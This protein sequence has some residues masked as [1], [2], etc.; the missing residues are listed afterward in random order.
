MSF[1]RASVVETARLSARL[2]RVVLQVH[3]PAA[4]DVPSAGDS[5]IGLY[6]SGADDTAESSEGR[7]YSVRCHSGNRITVDVVLHT[8][9]PGTEWASTTEPGARVGLDHA[10]SWYR[11]E[12]ETEWQLLVSDLSGLPATA[13]IL[14]ETPAGTPVIVI[15]E[16]A[17]GE[18]LDYLP[19]RADTTV[20]ASIGTGNGDAPSALARTVADLR[21]PQG[22]GYCWF[23]GEAAESRA[24]RKYLRRLGWTVDQYDI[25]GYWR[26]DSEAWDTRFAELQENLLAVYQRAVSDGKSDKVALEEFDEACARVGL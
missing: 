10:R 8:Q 25:T 4:L 6:F 11:P 17:V 9:G 18:D 21:L 2:Q 23:A 5:A 12:P 3:E 19:E 14:E 22:R 13:R 15:V 7:T 1:S 24:V 20:I 16:V 26:H